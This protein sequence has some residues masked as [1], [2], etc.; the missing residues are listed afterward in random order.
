MISSTVGGSAEQRKS[1]FGGAHPPSDQASR[2]VSADG[3]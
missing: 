2:P 1:L 3:R